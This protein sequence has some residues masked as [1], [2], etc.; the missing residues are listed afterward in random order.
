MHLNFTW[1]SIYAVLYVVRIQPYCST[2]SLRGA[3]RYVNDD[4]FSIDAVNLHSY[5]VKRNAGLL[6][7]LAYSATVAISVDIISVA[8]H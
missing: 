4:W 1:T 3:D 2:R 6:D 8:V 5:C 7:F